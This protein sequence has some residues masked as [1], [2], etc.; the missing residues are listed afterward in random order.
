MIKLLEEGVILPS[1]QELWTCRDT[2][3]HAFYIFFF[4]TGLSMFIF[5]IYISMTLM[6]MMMSTL[7]TLMLFPQDIPNISLFPSNGGGLGGLGDK[8]RYSFRS[9]DFRC[10]LLLDPC[11]NARNWSLRLNEKKFYTLPIYTLHMCTIRICRNAFNRS[12]D[13]FEYIRLYIW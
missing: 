3:C 10:I 8:G 6:M 11:L 12:V 4:S 7:A 2:F 9:I 13:V 5:M 1:F